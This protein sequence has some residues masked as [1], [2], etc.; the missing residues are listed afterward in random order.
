[1]CV[2]LMLSEQVL[3]QWWHPV[4]SSKAL[5]LP[6]WAMRLV[7]YR[8]IAM[9]I[10]TASK[11]GVCFH[12]CVFACCPGGCQG[13]TEQVVAK[14]RLPGTSSVSLDMLHWAMPCALLPHIHMAI[15]MACDGG[16]F[17]C[18]RAFLFAVILA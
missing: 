5:D 17:A 10:K 13:N 11:V 18:C 2:Q 9:A 12:H 14:R 6:Y 16:A 15:Q 7:L 1:M 3:A 8:H 4:A